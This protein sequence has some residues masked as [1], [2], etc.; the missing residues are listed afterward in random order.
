MYD[1]SDPSR[2]T[3]AT[4]IRSISALS[5]LLLGSWSL[6]V[7]KCA[8]TDLHSIT[9][10]QT[11]EQPSPPRVA[12]KTSFQN[13]GRS[14]PAWTLFTTHN[15]RNSYHTNHTSG[16]LQQWDRSISTWS[17]CHSSR[18]PARFRRGNGYFTPNHANLAHSG[19][20]TH[21]MWILNPPLFKEHKASDLACEPVHLHPGLLHP[22]KGD[23]QDLWTRNGYASL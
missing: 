23:D 16:M 5:C 10:Y 3:H 13:L 17:Q 1:A 20:Q 19:H 4:T 11:Q 14:K 6:H 15:T 9:S 8:L 7:L 21:T 22:D 2:L 12:H 18:R